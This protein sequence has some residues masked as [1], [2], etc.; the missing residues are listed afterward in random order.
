MKHHM[1]TWSLD[2][3]VLVLGSESEVKAN[4]FEETLFRWCVCTTFLQMFSYPHFCLKKNM[5]K[6]YRLLMSEDWCRLLKSGVG[7]E[8]WFLLIL[9]RTTCTQ[10]V[11]G[12][13]SNIQVMASLAWTENQFREC[14]QQCRVNTT[15][16]P[17]LSG[18][19]FA[20]I[21]CRIK[22]SWGQKICNHTVS[23]HTVSNSWIRSNWVLDYRVIITYMRDCYAIVI[24]INMVDFC[25][26][27]LHNTFVI[28]S[29]GS[30]TTLTN[31]WRIILKVDFWFPKQV[32]I[33]RERFGIFNASYIRA[34]YTAQKTQ[35]RSDRDHI[36]IR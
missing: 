30:N 32:A 21:G 11:R 13:T 36:Q 24:I 10:T 5:Y 29:L 16:H 2:H 6:L 25:H 27:F 3:F 20:E 14:C 34:I 12:N 9:A 33:G 28:R 8:A 15:M 18:D 31:R 35:I 1:S 26:W 22:L 19:N 7:W 4:I 17:V 23:N